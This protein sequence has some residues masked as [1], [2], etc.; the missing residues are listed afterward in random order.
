MY[1]L[2]DSRGY[3]TCCAPT[4]PA[5]TRTAGDEGLLAPITIWEWTWIKPGRF[6]EPKL[7]A[8]FTWDGGLGFGH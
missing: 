6:P 4:L 7:A 3:T 1:I 5:L 2:T 8:K